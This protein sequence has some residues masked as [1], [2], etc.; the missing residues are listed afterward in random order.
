MKWIGLTGGIGSG[1][2]TVSNW[3]KKQKIPLV[4]ADE[5]AH[6][7]VNPGTPG[8]EQ[9]VAM[10]GPSMLTDEG[11][12]NRKK[13]GEMVFGD[14]AKLMLLERILHPLI[15]QEVS[16]QRAKYESEGCAFA[17]YDVP[18][19]Y[20]KKMQSQ[21]D[22]VIVVSAP[23]ALQVQRIKE[24]DG[25]SDSEIQKRLMQQLPM[26]EKESKSDYI[27][28]NEGTL[29]DLEKQIAKVV[30]SLQNQYLSGNA[31]VSLTPT[32]KSIAPT[33]EKASTRDLLRK[34]SKSSKTKPKR[35]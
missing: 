13:M 3:I 35:K 11:H 19:L 24:R 27:I 28:R 30:A 17:I 9:V 7:V 2:S 33:E 10:F 29:Q 25:L 26:A 1:K 14:K 6:Q 32:A 15:Q 4:D 22:K 23:Q 5:I 18:L 31:Q 21:F 34:E 12:L 16:R 8:L 20:E